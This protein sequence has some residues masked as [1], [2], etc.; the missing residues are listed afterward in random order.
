MRADN[1]HPDDLEMTGE[2]QSY[3]GLLI[4]RVVASV[5]S[6]TLR[7]DFIYRQHAAGY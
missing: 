5:L 2:H 7:H 6:R 4:A 1:V 3:P